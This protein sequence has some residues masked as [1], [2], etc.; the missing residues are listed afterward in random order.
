M[1]SIPNLNFA[2]STQP[3]LSAEDLKRCM[4]LV[5]DSAPKHKACVVTPRVKA[6][7]D[8]QVRG[9]VRLR[10]DAIFGALEVC[11]KEQACDCWAFSDLALLRRYLAGEVTEL[12]LMKLATGERAS[13]VKVGAAEFLSQEIFYGK[14]PNS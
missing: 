9:V 12:E 4:D 5:K 14:I 13:V 10:Q 1:R 3:F 2:T 6:W 7:L 8:A 11:V